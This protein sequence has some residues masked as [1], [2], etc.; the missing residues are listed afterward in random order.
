MTPLLLAALLSAPLRA[1]D[2]GG[3]LGPYTMS[4][5]ASGTS[6]QPD[7]SPHEGL[8][9]MREDWSLMAHGMA[10]FVFDHQGG[11]RGADKAFAST[12]L[13]GMARRELS[14][15]TLGL[16]AM[17]SL[18]P[19]LVGKDGYPLLLQSGETTDGVTTLVDRQH[20]HDLFMELSASYS[21]PFG[22][23]GSAFAYAGLPGEPALGPP[24]FMHR[25]SGDEL[26]EAPITHHWLD[27]T[28][29]AMGV[30]TAGAT[31]GPVKLDASRFTGR[32]PNQYRWDIDRPLFDSNA[33]RLTVNPAP[34]WS[35]QASYGHIR[36]PEQ[37]EPEVDVDRVTA[38][39]S[40]VLPLRRG[41]LRTTFAWGRNNQIPG[42]GLDA[43]LLESTLR[44]DA[45]TV[46][47]RAERV[48]KDELSDD[49]TPRT[50]TKTTAGYLYDFASFARCRWGAGASGSVMLVPR[51]LRARYGSAPGAVMLFIR[52]KLG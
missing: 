13:M 10:Q 4:R 24:T 42:P 19:A 33:V 1:M 9:V 32:E 12:M 22:D 3:A 18:D 15:G 6:W 37:L 51:A 16:R 29:V 43:F 36:G 38:S 34:A 20:P 40:H 27:S 25:G 35:L 23:K 50:V 52:A 39:A 28:H 44:R 45:H 31:W 46:F 5:E 2:M 47:A 41:D 49:R 21:V 7:A 14:P 30:A 17:L 48:D 11:P 26:P 8:H